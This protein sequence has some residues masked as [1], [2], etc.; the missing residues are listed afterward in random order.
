MVQGV[1]CLV[2]LIFI[3]YSVENETPPYASICRCLMWQ[4]MPWQQGVTPCELRVKLE[5]QG[6]MPYYQGINQCNKQSAIMFS[7]GGWIPPIVQ[8]GP[9]FKVIMHAKKKS[10]PTCIKHME[11]PYVSPLYMCKVSMYEGH[12]AWHMLCHLR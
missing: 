5:V 12:L 7:K 8:W 3:L 1:M 6:V 4:V 9:P 11:A 2:R 10:L